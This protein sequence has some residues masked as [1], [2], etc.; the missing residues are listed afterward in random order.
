MNT[1]SASNEVIKVHV[2]VFI[3]PYK[4]SGSKA[5][6]HILRTE[7]DFHPK[8]ATGY[9]ESLPPLTARKTEVLHLLAQGMNNNQLSQNLFISELT[10]RNHINNILR[11]L[12]VHTRLAAVTLALK[13]HLI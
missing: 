12:K 4:S 8:L 13:N 1:L 9:D 3:L 6:L 5:L 11:K 2:F 10:V 7:E